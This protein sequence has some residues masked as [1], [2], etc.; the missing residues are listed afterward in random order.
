MTRN[1]QRM[2]VAAVR[3]S[4][5]PGRRRHD[6][7]DERVDSAAIAGSAR[8]SPANLSPRDVLHLQRTV[9]NRAVA[10]LL[11]RSVVQRL[12]YATAYTDNKTRSIINQSEGRASPVNNAPGHPRQHVGKWEKAERFAEEQGKTKSV[13]KDT[14]AQD[15]A[16]AAALN[17]A[18]GQ[19][20]LANL[21]GNPAA[22]TRGQI[23]NVDIG[24]A[25]VKVVKAKKKRGALLVGPMLPGQVAR[26]GAVKNWDLVTG[27]ASKATVIV[28]SMGTNVNGDIHIQTAFPVLD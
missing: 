11:S 1:S 19:G 3:R 23:L 27:V 17:S 7:F 5:H 22:P 15:K 10:N 28:D 13:F 16:V 18:A 2:H 14:A 21:D 20:A 25:D 4:P 12:P 26:P 6:T 9:G 8:V 24:A